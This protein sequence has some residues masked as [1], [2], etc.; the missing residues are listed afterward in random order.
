MTCSSDCGHHAKI[1]KPSNILKD[2][3]SDAITKLNLKTWPTKISTLNL[4]L[5]VITARPLQTQVHKIKHLFLYYLCFSV[6]NKSH[7]VKRF[8]TQLFSNFL[9]TCDH[10]IFHSCLP[11]VNPWRLSRHKIKYVIIYQGDSNCAQA[12]THFVIDHLQPELDLKT[13]LR[14]MEKLWKRV[15]RDKI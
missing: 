11:R 12:S 13:L 8:D 2:F 6:G 9:Y 15:L 3:A 7:L 14:R 5:D 10:T 1:T 4:S